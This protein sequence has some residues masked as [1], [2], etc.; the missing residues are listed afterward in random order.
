MPVFVSLLVS[1]GVVCTSRAFPVR[2]FVQALRGFCLPPSVCGA[3][4]VVLVALAPACSRLPFGVARLLLPLP[5]G[6][7]AVWDASPSREEALKAHSV[8]SQWADIHWEELRGVRIPQNRVPLP[9]KK[10]AAL[11]STLAENRVPLPKRRG[12][13]CH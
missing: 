4:G 12:R 7:F 11:P 10:G 13:H 3:G 9:I 6:I 2:M 8:A 5:S 1:G